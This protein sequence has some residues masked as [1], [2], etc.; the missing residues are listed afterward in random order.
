M[1][2]PSQCAKASLQVDVGRCK[3]PAVVTSDSRNRQ[4][5]ERALEIGGHGSH[6]ESAELLTPLNKILTIYL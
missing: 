4:K 5:R 2:I 1:K 3:R 6:T